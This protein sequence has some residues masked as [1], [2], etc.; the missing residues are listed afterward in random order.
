MK[1]IY[2][3]TLLA[4]GYCLSAQNYAR[5]VNP[6]I[7]TGG[8]GHTF[9][10]AVL[11]F[12]MV[13]LS[14]D[15]RIDGS[16]DGCGGYHYS[17]DVI[18]GFSHT[19]LSGTGCSDYGDVMLMPMVGEPSMDN[20]VYS[21]KFSHQKE[22]ASA[23]FYEVTLDDDNIKVE[24]S[25]TLRTGFHRYT[26]PKTDKANIILDLMHRD[27]TLD[28]DLRI[29]DNV[30]VAGY[31]NS[32]AWAK[33]QKIFF[34]IK[35]SKPFKK[36]QYA[37]GKKLV[38]ALNETNKE[39]PEGACFQFDVTDGN[40]LTVKVGLS[41]TGLEG[42]Q[43]NL[44]AESQHWGFEKFKLDAE[45][46]WN[47]ELNKIQITTD[48]KDKQTVFYTALYHC[49]IHPSI[50]MDVDGQY[51]GRDNKVHKA[52]GFTY[53]S[54]FSLWDTFRSLHP[55]FTI[56]QPDRTREFIRTFLQQYSDVGRLPV[57]ELSGYETNCMPGYHAVSVITD[58]YNKGIH[59]YD[60]SFM[61]TAMKVSA[62]FTNNGIPAYVKN[63]FL[64]MDDESESVS[65]T[66]EYAYDDWCIA[67][68]ANKL[69][70]TEDYNVFMDRAQSYK[71]LYDPTTGFMRPRKNGSWLSPFDP[72]EV[73]NHYT[74]ANSWQYSFFVPQD[75]SGLIALHGGD[76][77]FE[78]KLDSLFNTSSKTT[79]R[80]QVDIT[81]MIGQY[82]HG[83]EPSHHMA[84]LYNF[85][86]KPQKTIEKVNYILNTF[87]TNT[88]EGLIGN[89]DCGAL[90][91]WYVF[92]AM[93]FYPVCPGST[94][95]VLAAPQFSPIKISLENWQNF[96][97]TSKGRSATAQY[98]S[99]ISINS[100][101]KKRSS[102]YHSDIMAGGNMTFNF[103]DKNDET[104]KYG[105]SPSDR[106]RSL[107]KDSAILLSPIIDGKSKSFKG[108]QEVRINHSNDRSAI[109]YYTTNGTEPTRKSTVY[110][111]AILVDKT[112]VV[113]SRVYWGSDSSKT[114]T[115]S[116]YKVPNNWK[117][118][119]NCKYNSQ[120]SAGGDEGI[121]DGI[122]GDVNWRK[123]EWQGYQAQDFEC[124][125]DLGGAKPVSTISSNYL[126]D[127]RSWIV[128]PTEVEYFVSADGKNYKPV[129]KVSNDIKADNYDIQLKK[130]ELKLD[131]AESAKF[132]KVKA[133]NF[134]KLPEWHL[135]SGGDAFIFIDE[136]NVK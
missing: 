24:L 49:M 4:L 91:A 120:Y 81:G 16:W 116:F 96:E 128:F 92:G 47:R 58:A 117:V 25:A 99:E 54:V 30:T 1:K 44:A 86:G 26:F 104:N 101:S 11:P 70:R 45:A 65:K 46:A 63:G 64:Q 59:G 74:E 89:D 135:G 5:M 36:M 131:K 108:S 110:S 107:I 37:K 72:K 93:G 84:Y 42:A 2:L 51:W 97:I 126:Q 124:T 31:R 90:S 121:I 43:K 13:A 118:S 119:L 41:T 95:Y 79:G 8:H 6:F 62:N 88:P 19:H 106:P 67:K 85:A 69:N 33:E 130:F 14:P 10:G 52:T 35:F 98:V 21:S 102:I 18:Y 27:K 109:V 57:W 129:G 40:P 115:A 39:K 23:G 7:G 82:A 38:D 112:C 9:P 73:S 127:T 12:G 100:K 48:D 75:I 76:K 114:T 61:L 134:G 3:F 55:L 60:S 125:I 15:T 94:E 113:K 32:E 34:V 122:N 103:T 123:G 68:F 111:K 78:D 87:Y 20:K 71:N 29:I 83:N 77:K 56:I 50:A 28:C 136:I 105:V 80:Q 132:I 53:Y 66:L 17:D 22:K 133:K